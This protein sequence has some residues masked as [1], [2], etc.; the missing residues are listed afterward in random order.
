M[1]LKLKKFAKTF[2]CIFSE[3]FCRTLGE[4][5]KGEEELVGGGLPEITPTLFLPYGLKR[6]CM[7]KS[8]L[9]GVRAPGGQGYTPHM[10]MHMCTP[11]Y[12]R[13]SSPAPADAKCPAGSQRWGPRAAS[14]AL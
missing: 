4:E 1:S 11:G 6:G 2:Q 8:L 14:P 12:F 7:A 13:T 5:E 9:L 3:L 10:Y